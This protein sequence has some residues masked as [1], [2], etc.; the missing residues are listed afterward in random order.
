VRPGPPAGPVTYGPARTLTVPLGTMAASDVQTITLTGLKAGDP[1][2][3]NQARLTAN[4]LPAPGHVTGAASGPGDQACYGPRAVDFTTSLKTVTPDP[5]TEG[6]P[7]VYTLEVT[8]S[9]AGLANHL[10]VTDQLPACVDDSAFDP[11]LHVSAAPDPPSSVTY[12]PAGRLLTIGLERLAPLATST[13][14]IAGLLAGPATGACCNQA[15]ISSDEVPPFGDPTGPTAGSADPTCSAIQATGCDL[16]KATA[17]LA[18]S[19]TPPWLYTNACDSPPRLPGPPL[20]TGVGTDQDIDVVA[21]G[22][23]GGELSLYQLD[24][25]CTDAI[26]LTKNRAITPVAVHIHF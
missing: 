8:N 4:E 2:C 3:C 11:R 21:S 6:S 24:C 10:V 7:L 23:P 20:V 26:R 9:G 18:G 19:R 17:A 12:Q 14:T 5:L 22:A 13:V 15:F 16:D 25:P 1:V